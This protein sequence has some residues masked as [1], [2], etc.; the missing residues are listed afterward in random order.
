MLASELEDAS[1]G[2]QTLGGLDITVARNA[3]GTQLDSFET[4]IAVSGIEG[5]PL[6]VAFIRAPIVTRIGPGVTAIATLP[7]SRIVGVS[8]G[9]LIGVSFHPEITG[10]ERVHRM[11]LDLVQ[12]RNNTVARAP[13]A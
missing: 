1:V 11:F 3:F 2:Q 9:Q 12:A 13:S 7:D 4:D 6:R 10:D 5:D 8:N